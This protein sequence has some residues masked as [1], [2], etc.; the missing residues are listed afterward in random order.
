VAGQVA[1][2]LHATFRGL[3]RKYRYAHRSRF[4]SGNA[5]EN[6]LRDKPSFF[7]RMSGKIMLGKVST[8]GPGLSY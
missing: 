1:P 7:I 5:Q 8:E 4:S 2:F 6:N 3:Q